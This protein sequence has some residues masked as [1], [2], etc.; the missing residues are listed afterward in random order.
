MK[1]KCFHVCKPFNMFNMFKLLPVIFNAC[2]LIV[3]EAIN[4]EPWL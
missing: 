3:L 4:K 2:Q 1:K